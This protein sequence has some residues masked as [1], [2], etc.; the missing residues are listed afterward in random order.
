MCGTEQ[1][2][3]RLTKQRER[4]RVRHST[5]TG[6]ERRE[7]ERAQCAAEIDEQKQERMRKR[8]ERDRRRRS[9]QTANES[10]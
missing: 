3:E 2:Q 1:R 4:D 9:T 7:R 8:R 10:R 5:Q 6:D